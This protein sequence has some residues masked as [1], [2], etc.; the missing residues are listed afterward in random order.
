MEDFTSWEQT[1]ITGNVEKKGK[2]SY[3]SWP[4]AVSA[5]RKACPEGSWTIEDFDGSPYKTTPAGCF[6]IVTVYPDTKVEQGF[7]QVHPV[8]NNKN[9]TIMEPD[10]FQVNTSIQR[11]LVK[12]IALATGIGLHLYAGEDLPPDGGSDNVVEN[13][14]EKDKTDIAK[15]TSLE[16]LKNF[17][18][19]GQKRNAVVLEEFN[20]LITERKKELEPEGGEN[21][22]S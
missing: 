14:S 2:F 9:K 10:S 18:S 3:L 20:K 7:T 5:F 1:D 12:A 13:V 17:W 4:F 22:D 16:T 21:G 19:N 15:I 11:C 6:V 8:L